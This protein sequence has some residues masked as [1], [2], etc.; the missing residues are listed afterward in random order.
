FT[1]GSLLSFLVFGPM[2]DIKGIGLM[3]S[4]FQ[5]KAIIYIFALAAQLTFFLTLIMNLYIS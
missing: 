2:I 5:T 1:S 3:L 4:I